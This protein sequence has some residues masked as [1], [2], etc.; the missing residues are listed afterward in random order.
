MV[1]ATWGGSSRTIKVNINLTGLYCSSWLILAEIELWPHLNRK[2]SCFHNAPKLL[3]QSWTPWQ[4]VY[5]HKS[6]ILSFPCL[7]YN[8]P[9]PRCLDV[10]QATAGC[11][12]R[13][14]EYDWTL[15]ENDHQ[16]GR[17]PLVHETS[18]CH[19]NAL[20][21]DYTP[22]NGLLDVLWGIILHHPS[23]FWTWIPSSQMDIPLLWCSPSHRRRHCH[24][25]FM[26]LNLIRR[27]GET[28]TNWNGGS[29]CRLHYDELD[30]QNW[31]GSSWHSGWLNWCLLK[32]RVLT[33]RKL[34]GPQR[35]CSVQT[36]TQLL[37]WMD[38]WPSL[39]LTVQTTM[40]LLTW[41]DCW[42]SLFL[43]VQT[44]V[45]LLHLSNLLWTF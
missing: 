26:L 12:C 16:M 15:A 27:E 24:C 31:L 23:S 13:M 1:N 42:P 25:C 22:C 44:T 28:I 45:Q 8:G 40:Q 11:L 32:C 38:C 10:H 2:F 9:Q 18:G 37:T 6:S 34:L 36:T 41:M 19:R 35:T 17:L 7:P 29:Y 43:L 20:N 33:Q 3:L 21:K 14:G 5:R 39:F 30:D 4:T